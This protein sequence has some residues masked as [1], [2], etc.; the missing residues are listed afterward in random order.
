MHGGNNKANSDL[1]TKK[2]LPC[3]LLERG[4]EGR[5]RGR[6][7]RAFHD[8]GTG[9]EIEKLRRVARAAPE[10]LQLLCRRAPG[11]AGDVGVALAGSGVPGTL[12]LP[13]LA[14]ALTFCIQRFDAKWRSTSCG[15]RCAMS[16]K[17]ETRTVGGNPENSRSISQNRIPDLRFTRA[18]PNAARREAAKAWFRPPCRWMCLRT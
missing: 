15:Y 4:K 13:E 2:R 5:I 1:Q 3:L 14:A 10:G 8:G 16:T 9:D 11:P 7:S 6:R 17:N 18:G 12:P